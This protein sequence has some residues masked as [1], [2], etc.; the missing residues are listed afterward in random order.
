MTNKAPQINE[1]TVSEVRNVAISFSGKLD[2]DELLTGTPTVVD[3]SPP[4]PETLVFANIAVNTSILTINGVSVPVGEAVQFKVT[5]GVADT[6]YD[7]QINCGT[8]ANP[9]QTLIGVAELRVKADC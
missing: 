3:C 2:S 4:S 9:A 6:N 5:G 8:D 7:I 1:K